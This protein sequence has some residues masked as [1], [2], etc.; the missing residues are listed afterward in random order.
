MRSGGAGAIAFR[1][2]FREWCGIDP[3]RVPVSMAGRTDLEILRLTLDAVGAPYPRPAD[4]RRLVRIYLDHLRREILVPERAAPLPGV[5]A[6]LDGLHARR[7]PVGLV[8]GNIQPG[9][10]IKLA[11]AGLADR[12]DFGAFGNDREDR[13]ELVPVALRRLRRRHGAE[14]RPRDVWVVG[15]TLRDVQCARAAGVRILAVGTGFE[16]QLALESA[17]PDLYLTDLSDTARVLR[18]L[19]A[20]MAAEAP[21]P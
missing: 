1:H 12:F 10:T 11:A 3:S 9:A 20:T 17:R 2:A 5:V 19:G 4:R 18:R 7:L 14:P 6:L 15:D 13:D 16:D 8:T 21:G